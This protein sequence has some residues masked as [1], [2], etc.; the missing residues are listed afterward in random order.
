MK[1]ATVSP[2]L[3]FNIEQFLA[4]DMPQPRTGLSSSLAFS[5]SVTMP[6]PPLHLPHPSLIPA[7]LPSIGNS[8]E[9]LQRLPGSA[10]CGGFNE[11]TCQ[12]PR[13]WDNELHNVIH[14]SFNSTASL[15]SQDLSACLPPG[16]MKAE[17]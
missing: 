17:P 3:D 9:T 6:F 5:P 1:L 15:N 7:S 10:V 13:I 2:R 12:T 11:P 14:N 8:S 4:K 16:H